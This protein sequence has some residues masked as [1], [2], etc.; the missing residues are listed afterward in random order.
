MLK[1]LVNSTIVDVAKKL[2]TSEERVK[3]VLERRIATKVNWEK[4]QRIEILGIDEIALKK[5]HRDYVVLIT[6]P[7]IPQGVEVLA[8]LPD[9]KKET[10]VKFFASIP[11]RLR[12]S[13]ERVC[14]DMYLGFVNAAREQLPRA[15]IIIERFHVAIGEATARSAIAY[16]NCA[17][18]CTSTGTQAA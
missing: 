8:V 6:T 18:L 1:L 14:T 4:F 9:R 13:I 16:H 5:G 3:G 10:V 17:E 7:S 15:H 12:N 11:V 2:D